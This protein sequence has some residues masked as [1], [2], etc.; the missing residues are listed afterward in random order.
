MPER[1]ELLKFELSKTPLNQFCVDFVKSQLGKLT[2]VVAIQAGAAEAV[3]EPLNAMPS[4]SAAIVA[5][6]PNLIFI[7]SLSQLHFR[8]SDPCKLR[9]CDSVVEWPQTLPATA[10][11]KKTHRYRLGL[12]VFSGGD[13]GI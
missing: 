6:E 3:F 11:K 2:F 10:K 5:I 9:P 4:A 12:F 8:L 1:F 7:I 13:G